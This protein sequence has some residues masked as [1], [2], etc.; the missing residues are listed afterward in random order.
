MAERIRFGTSPSF[1]SYHRRRHPSQSKSLRVVVHK[2]TALISY[3]ILIGCT[4]SCAVI[5]VVLFRHGLYTVHRLNELYDRFAGMCSGSF[6]CVDECAGPWRQS[7]AST[8]WLHQR[9]SWL[10]DVM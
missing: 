8:T 6:P 9:T 5:H 4:L 7:R 1:S 10:P 2:Q 3:R